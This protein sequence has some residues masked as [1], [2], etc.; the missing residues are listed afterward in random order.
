MFFLFFLFSFKRHFKRW[1]ARL[2]CGRKLVFQKTKQNKRKNTL[3]N[4]LLFYLIPISQ[5]HHFSSAIREHYRWQEY[6]A[7]I[8]GNH[9]LRRRVKGSAGGGTDTNKSQKR[10]LDSDT[11][12]ICNSWKAVT[13]WLKKS[14]KGNRNA[15]NKRL[16]GFFC[17]FSPPLLDQLLLF[18]L[19]HFLGGGWRPPGDPI[20]QHIWTEEPCPLTVPQPKVQSKN[21]HTHA[22]TQPDTFLGRL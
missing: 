7:R 18:I 8:R 14:D 20:W 6:L 13:L 19:L 12:A 4:T 11:T 22:H 5:A 16:E 17:F 21:T 1:E 9:F 10:R 3:K 15:G 2:H